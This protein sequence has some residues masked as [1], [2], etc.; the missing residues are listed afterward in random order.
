MVPSVEIALD[1]VVEPLQFCDIKA[2]K[3]NLVHV[4]Q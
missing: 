4:A 1:Y 3:P 2:H